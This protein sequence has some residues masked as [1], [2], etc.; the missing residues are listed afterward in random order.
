LF[1]ALANFVFGLA[2]DRPVLIVI[3]D[4][5]WADEAS[6]DFLYHLAR[7]LADQRV[8]LLT[9]YRVDEVHPSFNRWL[10]QLSHDRLA[11][12]MAIRALKQ[13]EVGAMLN[14]MVGTG[15]PVHRDFVEELFALTEGNPFFVE[16][17]MAALVASGEIDLA[18]D[19]WDRHPLEGVAV[20]RSVQDAVLRRTERLVL[21]L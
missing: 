4:I 5:H 19:G 12:E 20:P 8:L 21:L 17:L 2:R 10:A 3:E 7:S 14:A 13:D 15:R 9:T 16:E 1:A 6:L 11:S 18:E